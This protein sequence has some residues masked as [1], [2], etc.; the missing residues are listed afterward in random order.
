[1]LALVEERQGRKFNLVLAASRR[2]CVESPKRL[3][4]NLR[5][6]KRSKLS[7]GAAAY[8]VCGIAL[9]RSR[10]ANWS[11]MPHARTIKSSKT[12]ICRD[13]SRA[14]PECGQYPISIFRLLMLLPC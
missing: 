13:L 11:L 7:T 14:V 8:P 4:R 3:C 1:M 5:H 10:P 9:G 2:R 6:C 12:V